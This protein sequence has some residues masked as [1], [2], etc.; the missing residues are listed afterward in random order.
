M[1]TLALGSVWGVVGLGMASVVT[2]IEQTGHIISELKRSQGSSVQSGV[3]SQ[4]GEAPLRS[5]AL[6]GCF[7]LAQELSLWKL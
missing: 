5:G 3:S 6:A 2:H 1:L 7:V 4:T